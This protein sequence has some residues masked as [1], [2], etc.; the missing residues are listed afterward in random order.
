MKFN[1]PQPPT[2]PA[3]AVRP[4]PPTPP[5]IDKTPFAKNKDDAAPQITSNVET[6]EDMARDAVAKGAGALTKRTVDKGGNDNQAVASPP[7]T[8]PRQDVSVAKSADTQSDYDR[9]QDVLREFRELD[10][11]DAKSTYNPPA[12]TSTN[13]PHNYTVTPR[14][15]QQEGHGVV[16]WLFTIIFVVVSAFVIVKK[17]LLTNEKPLN[18]EKQIPTKNEELAIKKP[19]SVPPKKDDDKGKHFEVR[20]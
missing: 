5:S 19:V 16:Y 17:F 20:V 15:S 8:T 4:K 12:Q 2:I 10:A 11:R 6:P 14:L 1:P 18:V 9:G 13:Q 3:P 7:V